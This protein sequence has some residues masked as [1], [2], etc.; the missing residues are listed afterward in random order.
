MMGAWAAWAGRTALSALSGVWR[1][2][3]IAGGAVA[4]FLLLRAHW[5]SEGR[6]EERERQEQQ[7]IDD[8]HAMAD[9]RRTRPRDRDD[10]VDRLHDGSF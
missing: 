9:A 4:A 6:A 3:A 1:Y 5:R 10:L 2:L 7:V 8:E